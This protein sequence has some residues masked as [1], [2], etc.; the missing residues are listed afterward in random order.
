[1]RTVRT[2]RAKL[3]EKLEADKPE[4]VTSLKRQLGERTWKDVRNDDLD[5]PEPED[6]EK[7]QLAEAHRMAK[8]L[9]HEFG[10]RLHQKAHILA[11]A[12]VICDDKLPLK[13]VQS[14]AWEDHME[15]IKVYADAQLGEF[16]LEEIEQEEDDEGED[17]RKKVYFKTRMEF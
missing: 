16:E 11:R 14:E 6:W 1:L 3:R 17:P 2:M 4:D 9:N 8:R 15:D 13:M 5:K 7:R 10:G 12:L